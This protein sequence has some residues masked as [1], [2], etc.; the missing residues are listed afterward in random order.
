MKIVLILILGIHGLIHNLGFMKAFNLAN[1]KEINKPVTKPAGILWLLTLLLFS[2]TAILYGLGNSHWW[3]F[4]LTAVFISQLLIISAWKDARYGTIPNVIILLI[5]VIACSTTSFHKMVLSER[6]NLLAQNEKAEPQIITPDRIGN[7]PYPV[8]KWLNQSG[9]VGKPEILSAYLRQTGSMK[10]KPSQQNWTNLTAEQ[11]FTIPTP[12]FVRNVDMQLFGFADIAGR[13][14][15]ENGRGEMLIKLMGLIPLADAGPDEKINSG[16]LQRFLSETVWSPSAALS[17]YICWTAIDSLTAQATM[18]Y[19]GVTG[20]GIFFFD[21]S[22]S[23]KKFVTMRYMGSGPEATLREWIIT[24]N[25]S[26]RMN[27]VLIPVKMAVT[28]GLEGGEWTW[29]RL[30]VTDVAYN[31]LRKNEGFKQ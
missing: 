11:Y 10:M 29:L 7:L 16:T 25:E 24:V 30:E 8:K 14:K 1:V 15:Y 18:T 12:G 4:G 31:I 28:W 20:S 26:K 19:K 5:S 6:D 17:P 22:G 9:I 27:G 2:A 3:L 21:D 23:F 13:D